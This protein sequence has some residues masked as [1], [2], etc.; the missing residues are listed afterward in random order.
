LRKL[1]SD[2][3]ISLDGYAK[4]EHSG[5][6]FDLYGPDLGRW[7]EEHLAEPQVL[8]MG[9][10]TYEALAPM[11][12]DASSGRMNELLKVVLSRTLR[13][14]LEWENS[15]L[16]AGDLTTAFGDLKQAGGDT[17]R[18]IGSVSLVRDLVA[19][20]LVDRLRLVVFPIVLGDHGR[21]PMFAGYDRTRFELVDISVLDGRL[22]ALEYSP[23]PD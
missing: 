9:R 18:T 21:E 2:L 1:I 5:P 16:L 22:L 23:R 11:R 15:R 3:F 10:V 6:Y 17:L 4:G 12:S 8:V 13:E 19:L 14:P 7:I 20:G